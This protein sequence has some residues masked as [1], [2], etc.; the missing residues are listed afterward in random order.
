MKPTKITYQP[1]FDFES[2]LADYTGA[3]Y[4]VATDGCTHAIELCMRYYNIKKCSSTAFTYISV[5]QCLKKLGIDLDLTDEQ[6]IGE[7]RFGGT[8]IWDSAR[9]LVK[10]MYRDGQ[11]QCL[12]FGINKPMSLGKVGAILL[13]DETAFKD[14]SKMR[15][16]GRDL[17]TYPLT[18]ATEWAEQQ[19]FGSAFHYCPTLED[20][21]NGLELI[22]T[23]SGQSQKIDYPD[24]RKLQINI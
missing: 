5:I 13:D 12:S 20:C 7:Y 3:P 23:F 8:N 19:S 11:V 24:C 15:A 10:N 2:A 18:G 16:D 14:L 6:W 21:S 1:I 22:K 9:K 17:Q 4:V